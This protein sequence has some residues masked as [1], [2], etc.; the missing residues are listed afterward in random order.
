[1]IKKAA[2]GPDED[3]SPEG[4]H[5]GETQARGRQPARPAMTSENGD[6]WPSLYLTTSISPGRQRRDLV[7]VDDRVSRD[8]G[9]LSKARS[10]VCQRE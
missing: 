3:G 6:R 8:S 2:S 4:R 1:M 9:S 10:G 7:G 5:P